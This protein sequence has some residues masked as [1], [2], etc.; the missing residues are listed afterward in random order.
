MDPGTHQW[1]GQKP[2]ETMFEIISLNKDGTIHH[3]IVKPDAKDNFI[4][5]KQDSWN[6]YIEVTW[7]SHLDGK[8]INKYYQDTN[9][10]LS[11]DDGY[12]KILMGIGTIKTKHRIRLKTKIDTEMAK[13]SPNALN[14]LTW[15][16]TLDQIKNWTPLQ[17]FT[18]ALTNLDESVAAGQPDKPAIRQL[19]TAKIASLQPQ[20]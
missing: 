16:Y 8:D 12:T 17:I 9:G 20:S 10:S 3:H 1:K 13:P 7:A 19:L 18:Q 6:S 11:Y 14:I 4:A 2:G 5:G 15:Q